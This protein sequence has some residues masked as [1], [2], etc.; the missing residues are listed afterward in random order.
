MN[1][2]MCS[3]LLLSVLAVS[4]CTL[5][6]AVP[7]PKGPFAS[8]SKIT[9]EGL[10]DAQKLVGKLNSLVAK[11]RVERGLFLKNKAK[12][13]YSKMYKLLQQQQDDLNASEEEVRKVGEKMDE[14]A[15][16]EAVKEWERL[17]KFHDDMWVY[18]NN[19]QPPLL[20]GETQSETKENSMMTKDDL[21]AI[22]AMGGI[23]EKAAEC[24]TDGE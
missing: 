19:K 8:C 7:V 17:Q 18:L 3:L 12:G 13:V 6:T 11:A 9:V 15:G 20:I 21:K 22:D 23:L 16:K 24:N 4:T 1:A 14:K 10:K 5:T 2:K